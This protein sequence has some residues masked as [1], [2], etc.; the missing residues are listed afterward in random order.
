MGGFFQGLA[1]G[2]GGVGR[3]LAQYRPEALAQWQ[4][5]RDMMAQLISKRLETEP[6]GSVA[7]DEGQ[8][9]LGNV[10]SVHPGDTKGLKH[11]QD[12]LTFSV[13]HPD[14]EKALMGPPPKPPETAPGPVPPGQSPG[15]LAP[16]I[17]Q[18]S[19]ELQSA[20]QP[21]TSPVEPQAQQGGGGMGQHTGVPNTGLGM[22]PPPTA[23]MIPP[24]G[25]AA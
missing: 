8:K 12:A 14:V 1:A 18:P 19:K 21:P 11:A 6:M 4:H 17:S 2:V 25:V 10:M 22:L 3:G 7:Y 23:P 15:S 5:T 24:P 9:L 16:M 13:V 20:A